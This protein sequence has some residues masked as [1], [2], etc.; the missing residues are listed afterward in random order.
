LSAPE[1]L[2][3]LQPK[4]EGGRPRKTMPKQKTGDSMR[5]TLARL[6]AT[7]LVAGLSVTPSMA[8]D[9]VVNVYNWSDYIDSSILDDFTKET[10]IK[11]V[12]DTFDSNEIAGNQ[13]AGRRHRLRRRRADRQSFLQRQIQAGVFQKL[14]KSKLPNLSNMWDV[15]TERVAKYDPG[16]E[17]ASTTCGAPR[18]H[19][20]QHRQGEGSTRHRRDRQLG[21]LLQSGS[22]PS[23]RI[24]A[25]TCWIRRPTSFRRR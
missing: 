17:Y 18:W 11:V 23:S 5:S 15:V 8:E 6:A 9:R 1:I 14:D 16:N 3:S 19:R 21:C 10:G 22:L 20:L 4:P 13:A 7:A 25:S 24:A 12:Y 2:S